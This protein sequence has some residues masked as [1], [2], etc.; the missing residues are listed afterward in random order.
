[1][2]ALQRRFQMYCCRIRECKDVSCRHGCKPVVISRLWGWSCLP[3]LVPRHRPG[4]LILLHGC[5]PA[6]REDPSHIPWDS[7]PVCGSLHLPV[8]FLSFFRACTFPFSSC[9]IRS[10]ARENR[11]DDYFS[12]SSNVILW[13]MPLLAGL[14]L[15]W[16]LLI[17]LRS[18]MWGGW[19]VRSPFNI[20]SFLPARAPAMPSTLQGCK[21]TG[22]GTTRG[23]CKCVYSWKRVPAGNPSD[24][25]HAPQGCTP[26][27]V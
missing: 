23:W 15:H 1:M 6:L 2:G 12:S 25:A 9:L 4:L 5:G 8:S 3:A 10:W 18:R 26:A 16:P 22:G 20:A 14:C 21:A 19:K 13:L 27:P 11:G 7:P 24:P 17:S